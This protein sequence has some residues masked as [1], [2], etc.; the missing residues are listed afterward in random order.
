MLR[1]GT[2]IALV[3]CA[4]TANTTARSR[5]KPSRTA[6]TGRFPTHRAAPALGVRSRHRAG[7][8]VSRRSLRWRNGR[9]QASWQRNRQMVGLGR[10]E[11]P[12]SPLSGARSSHLSYRPTSQAGKANAFYHRPGHAP[13]ARAN[14]IAPAGSSPCHRAAVRIVLGRLNALRHP[15]PFESR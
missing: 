13:S 5:E 4:Y 6:H 12:T 15:N 9:R 3:V 10:L 2:P 11:L 1:F 8:A 7:T 14:V